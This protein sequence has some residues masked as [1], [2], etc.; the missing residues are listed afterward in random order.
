[1]YVATPEEAIDF[2]FNNII[3]FLNQWILQT[4]SDFSQLKNNYYTE[5]LMILIEEFLGDV[6]WILLGF[7]SLVHMEFLGPNCH[8]IL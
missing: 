6:N 7:D 2:R 4:N 1:L 3:K 8:K 5:Q